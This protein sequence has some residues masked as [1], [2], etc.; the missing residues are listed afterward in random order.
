MEETE[1]EAEEAAEEAEE[2]E[3]EPKKYSIK[4][5]GE[6]HELTEDQLIEYAQKGIGFN[7][8]S[9]ARAKEHKAEMALLAEERNA[10]K[11]ELEQAKAYLDVLGESEAG[12]KH[13]EYLLEYDV[14]EYKRITGMQADVKNKVAQA[15]AQAEQAQVDAALDLLETTF[16]AEW[17]KTDTREKLLS[18]GIV[19]G[20]HLELRVLHWQGCCHFC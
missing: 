8:N 17:A 5:A 12:K 18:E 1:G 14:A 20:L 15:K 7:K 19:T 11:G 3:Q 10:L 16:P 4:A 13:L 2:V 9:E 6:M